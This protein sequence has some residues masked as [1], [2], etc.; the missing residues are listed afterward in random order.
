MLDTTK[1]VLAQA[2]TGYWEI[3]WSEPKGGRYVSRSHSTR[4]RSRTEAELYRKHWLKARAEILAQT[5]P[6]PTV[7]VLLD[8]YELNA[9]SRKVGATQYAVLD[10][11][12]QAFGPMQ[13]NEIDEEDLMDYRN[14]R[15]VADGTL[16]RELGV[17]VAVF[18][19]GVRKKLIGAGDVP[20]VDLPPEGQRRE[21]FLSVPEEAELTQI[22]LADPM[23]RVSRF[24]LLALRTGARRGAIKGL[25]WDRVDLERRFVDYRDPGLRTSKKRRVPVPVDDVL[26]PVLEQAQVFATDQFVIGAGRIRSHLENF[27]AAHPKFAHVTPHVLRHTAATRWLRDG[28]SLWDVAGLLGDTVETTTKVYG[29]HATSDLRA[30]MSRS[31]AA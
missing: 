9:K 30:A 5:S 23:S 17:L 1:Y 12:R 8:R 31:A 3:R 21:V 27:R 22:L 20:H 14:D 13:P 19:F 7:N 28:L 4:T 6:L 2:K 16:R 26:L 15:G 25:T 11:L 10:R 29:H 24:M 18:N